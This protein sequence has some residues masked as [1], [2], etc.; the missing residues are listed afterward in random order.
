MKTLVLAVMVVMLSCSPI[1]A[2]WGKQEK[3]VVTAQTESEKEEIISPAENTASQEATQ[4]QVTK[5][6]ERDMLIA[7]IN[8]LRNQEVR[9]A[10]LQQL[11]NEEIARLRQVQAVFC[12]QY[13]LDPEKFRTGLYIYDETQEKFI[14]REVEKTE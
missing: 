6:Q 4:E 11:L 3:K 8:A 14:E 9:V 13:K 7:N 5:Q 12:D 2:K 1:W 10:V